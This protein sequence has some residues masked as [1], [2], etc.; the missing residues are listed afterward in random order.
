MGEDLRSSNLNRA[1]AVLLVFA[2][3]LF[4]YRGVWRGVDTNG[5]DFTGRYAS[6]RALLHGADPY[7]RSV[8]MKFFAQGGAEEG[9]GTTSPVDPPSALLF[10]VPF[11]SLPWN[12]AAPVFS[13]FGLSLYFFAG[14]IA[15]RVMKLGENRT[16]LL[17]FGNLLFL[18]DPA[19]TMASICNPVLL[20]G[21]FI[22]ISLLWGFTPRKVLPGLFLGFGIAVK[23]QLG[24]PM[25]F[26]FIARKAWVVVAST[27]I[28]WGVLMAVGVAWVSSVNPSWFADMKA[29]SLSING[30]N[31]SLEQGIDRFGRIHL[32]VFLSHWIEDQGRA[33]KLGMVLVAIM[34]LV[35]L[36]CVLRA[37]VLRSVSNDLLILIPLLAMNLLFIYHRHYDVV[38]FLPVLGGIS[39]WIVDASNR[40]LGLLFLLLMSPFFV[41]PWSHTWIIVFEQPW[42]PAFLKDSIAI[43]MLL[44]GLPTWVMIGIM[45]IGTSFLALQRF[46]NKISDRETWE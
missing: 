17:C 4:L 40:R 23:P 26:F 37:R 21:P 13:L 44:L 20:A 1:L 46:P 34:G 30:L 2:V 39:M 6:A 38:V 28:T 8:Q 12:V 15:V 33:A 7:D 3:I 16:S 32:A 27:L 25:L 19:H 36:F 35:W 14:L 24:L 18:F 29:A 22:V 42:F 45:V 11:A 9:R 31:V 5:S 43:Q 10:Y 41:F